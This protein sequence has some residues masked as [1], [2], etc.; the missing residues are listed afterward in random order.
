MRIGPAI[1]WTTRRVRATIVNKAMRNFSCGMAGLVLGLAWCA[2]GCAWVHQTATLQLHPQITPSGVGAGRVVAVRVNDRRAS[3]IIGYRGV[4]SQNAAITTKQSIASLFEVKI[5]EGL[6]AKGFKAVAYA[7][8]ATDVLNVDVMEIKYTT[9]MEFM[10]GSMQAR[11]VLRVSTSKGGLYFDQN[12]YGTRK[13]TI[14][15]A[16]KASRNERIINAAISDAV[17]RMF[18]D[19]RLMLFLAN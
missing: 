10:R 15:E 17:Q 11:A 2:G 13:E 7:D 19:D 9:D 18:D 1:H 3:D 4:D 5:I 16:P 12:F 8:Q 6:G 14:V